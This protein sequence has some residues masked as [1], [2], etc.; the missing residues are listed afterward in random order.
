MSA[1]SFAPS[2]RPRCRSG[3]GHAASPFPPRFTTFLRHAD[4]SAA[5]RVAPVAVQPVAGREAPVVLADPAAVAA[6]LAALA[7]VAVAEAAAAVAAVAAVVVV[8]VVV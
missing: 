8:V 4:P 5:H 7:A 6:A 3:Q 1:S 2:T